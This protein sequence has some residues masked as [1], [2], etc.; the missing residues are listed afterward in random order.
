MLAKNPPQSSCEFFGI[1]PLGRVVRSKE[2][3]RIDSV[4]PSINRV[5][6]G[7]VDPI[8]LIFFLSLPS[9]SLFLVLQRSCDRRAPAPTHPSSTSG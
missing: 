6:R 7:G 1:E 9:L 4:D 8:P 2:P 3:Q 5:S